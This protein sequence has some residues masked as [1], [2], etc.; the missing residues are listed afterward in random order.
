MILK[1]YDLAVE[2]RKES[3]YTGKYKSKNP[4]VKYILRNFL[5]ELLDI[6][7]AVYKENMR[8]LDIGCGEGTISRIILKNFSFS[9]YGVDSSKYMA[10]ASKEF[11]QTV[12][13]SLYYLPFK[14]SSFDLVTCLEVLE[15][16]EKPE[17]GL[18]EIKRVSKQYSIVSV[19]NDRIFRLGNILRGKI[20]KL[21][22]GIDHVQRWSSFTF[23]KFLEK[24]FKIAKFKTSG[25]WLVALLER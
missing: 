3:K 14:N 22:N 25:V 24:E 21:G 9:Y 15:H 16:L 5:R 12:V 2:V 4:L 6:I 1:K 19:P 7:S 13:G 23:K 11:F 20:S 18:R 10:S 8:N 17:A